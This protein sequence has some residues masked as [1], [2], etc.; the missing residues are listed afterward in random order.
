MLINEEV[1]ISTVSAVHLKLELKRQNGLTPQQVSD[2]DDA[3]VQSVIDTTVLQVKKMF[4]SG[5]ALTKDQMEDLRKYMEEENK[6]SLTNALN[7]LTF[8][9]VAITSNMFDCVSKVNIDVEY[10]LE[11]IKLRKEKI[12]GCMEYASA[13]FLEFITVSD[14]TAEKTKQISPESQLPS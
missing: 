8:I 4:E 13:K 9:E 10:A 7:T 14:N 3:Q 1:V 11:Y 12:A 2:N 6:K 5:D